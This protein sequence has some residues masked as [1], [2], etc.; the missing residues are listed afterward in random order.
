M[1][2]TDAAV[3]YQLAIRWEISQAGTDRFVF[4]TPGSLEGKLDFTDAPLL[5]NYSSEV[6]NDGRVRW[7]IYLSR[8]QTQ[9]YFLSP[10]A[11]LPLPANAV[12]SYLLGGPSPA[13]TNEPPPIRPAP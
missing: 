6:L 13:G 3:V 5:Q 11:V 4:T 7:T 12:G 1:N 9:G 10:L 8:P 2:V